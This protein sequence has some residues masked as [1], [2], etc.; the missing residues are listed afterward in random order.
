MQKGR[1]V[2][3]EVIGKWGL[4]ET[5]IDNGYRANDFVTNNNNNNNNTIIRRYIIATQTYRRVLCN[6]LLQEL[7]TR[8]TVYW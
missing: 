4:H 8:L 7:I 1:D 5:S 6:S 3:T 2:L